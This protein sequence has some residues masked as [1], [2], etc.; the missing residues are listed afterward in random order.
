MGM[1]TEKHDWPSIALYALG[2]LFGS[3][4]GLW[5]M[6]GV[7]SAMASEAPGFWFVSR[8]AGVV[9]YVLLWASTAWGILMSSKAIKE[10]VPGPLAFTLHNVTAWLALGFSAVHAW[11][12]LGDRVVSFSL[13]GILL[14]FA[15]EYQPAWT[16]LGTLSLYVGLLVSVSFYFT[17]QIGYR[18]WRLIHALSYLM[19]VGVT[20]HSVRL[21]TDS[22]TPVM[23]AVYLLAG[24]SVLF[25]TVFRVLTMAIGSAAADRVQ[26]GPQR[27]TGAPE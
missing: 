3:L 25:L 8:A 24:A 4:L 18:T 10:L 7:A 12:L 20:L 16:G 9:G 5:V 2:S 19:F 6:K 21:G 14:P 22:S 26:T 23:Q 15:A 17:K 27:R 1:R 11:A 13:P